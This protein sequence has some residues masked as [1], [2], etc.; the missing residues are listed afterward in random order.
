MD[1]R[2]CQNQKKEKTEGATK[3]GKITRKQMER[4]DQMTAVRFQDYGETSVESATSLRA[5]LFVV[6]VVVVVIVVVPVVYI[7]IV[8]YL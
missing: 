2:L 1:R 7:V 8:S 6:V 4:W 5:T 3:I